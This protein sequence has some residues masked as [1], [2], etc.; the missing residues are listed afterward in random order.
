MQKASDLRLPLLV[1]RSVHTTRQADSHSLL[2]FGMNTKKS[3]EVDSFSQHVHHLTALDNIRQ[4]SMV[5]SQGIALSCAPTIHLPI[6][7]AYAFPVL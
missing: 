4:V 2:K 7:P 1:S 6:F 5:V 3:C